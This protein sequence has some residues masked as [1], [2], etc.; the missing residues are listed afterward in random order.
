MGIKQIKILIGGVIVL[1][2][3]ITCIHPVFPNEQ[4]LQHVGTLLLLMIPVMDIKSNRLSMTSFICVSLFI[5][6]HILGARYIYSFVPY[7]DWFKALFHIDLNTLFLTTRNHYDRIVHLFFG[8][9]AFP[10]LYELLDRNKGLNRFLKVLIVWSFIQSFSMMY[11]IFEW[12]LTTIM[13]NYDAN[14]YNG[15][16]GDLWDSQKDMLMAMFGSTIMAI[17]YLIKKKKTVKNIND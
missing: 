11:E 3:I 1:F 10:Y 13:S 2:G 14:N 7:N 4:F 16:Q 17:I 8:V 5:G 9:L 6:I 12:F 15:Q